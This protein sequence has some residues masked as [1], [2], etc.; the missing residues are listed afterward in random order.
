MS[1]GLHH[2]KIEFRKNKI[3]IRNQKLNV[4]TMN[5]IW[6]QA[7]AVTLYPLLHLLG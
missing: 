2:V 1:N 5:F 7:I 6:E 3:E 4:K